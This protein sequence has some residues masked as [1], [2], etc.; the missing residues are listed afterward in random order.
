MA[1][2]ILLQEGIF[3]THRLSYGIVLRQIYQRV[4]LNA[5]KLNTQHCVMEKAL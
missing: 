4:F 1:K 5:P 3:H 2:D